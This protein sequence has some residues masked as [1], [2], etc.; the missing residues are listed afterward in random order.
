MCSNINIFPMQLLQQEHRSLKV[1]TAVLNYTQAKSGQNRHYN[2]KAWQNAP[3]DRGRAREG[4]AH[5]KSSNRRQA[6]LPQQA[7][8]V[9]GE[10]TPLHASM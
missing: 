3:Q 4:P 7:Q 1:N 8:E 10:R 5:K 6:S 9:G 2:T